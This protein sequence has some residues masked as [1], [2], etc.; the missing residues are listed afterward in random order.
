MKILL[1]NLLMLITCQAFS[2]L[3]T[4]RISTFLFK[5]GIYNLIHI[6]T[7]LFH[8]P[9]LLFLAF[10]KKTW[11]VWKS[12]CLMQFKYGPLNFKQNWQKSIRWSVQYRC[13][14]G[15]APDLGMSLAQCLPLSGRK[16]QMVLKTSNEAKWRTHANDHF[17]SLNIRTL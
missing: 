16:C 1:S 7:I 13:M 12:E 3:T 17:L 15:N 8:S 14:C 10:A 9:S 4:D 11:F 5:R 6:F 2:F